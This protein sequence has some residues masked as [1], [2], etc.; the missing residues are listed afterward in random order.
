MLLI[1]YMNI[2]DSIKKEGQTSQCC[3]LKVCDAKGTKSNI[4]KTFLNVRA[5]KHLSKFPRDI[6][7]VPFLQLFKT[8]LDKAPGK[9]FSCHFQ[10][11]VSLY[12]YYD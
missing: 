5:I 11:Q 6:V 9:L 2:R 3:S 4:R 1:I 10:V 12:T 8:Y 7:D